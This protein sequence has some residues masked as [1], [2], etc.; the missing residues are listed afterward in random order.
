LKAQVN[1]NN[2]KLVVSL[3]IGKLPNRQWLNHLNAFVKACVAEPD[4]T[5]GATDGK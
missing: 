4:E 5:T 1:L 3:V 2:A